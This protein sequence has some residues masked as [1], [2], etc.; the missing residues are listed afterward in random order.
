MYKSSALLLSIV[1]LAACS[2]NS[3]ELQGKLT[4]EEQNEI[5]DVQT[6]LPDFSAEYKLN[7]EVIM[8]ALDLGTPDLCE[9]IADQA[10]KSSC[11]S[12]VADSQAMQSAIDN[13]DLSACEKLAS[14][15][16]Q[17]RCE[18][19]VSDQLAKK[20]YDQEVEA[21]ANLLFEVIS[22]GSLEQCAEIEDSNFRSDCEV[23]LKM[24]I[25]AEQ[26][27]PSY[28]KGLDDMLKKSCLAASSR[29]E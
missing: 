17:T 27:D 25:A 8:R 4:L 3:S 15:N 11:L 24:Q 14:L 19:L 22:E 28:C 26:K 12:L 9:T 13:L 7:E 29:Q 10:Q 16:M 5:V 23:N 20:S 1:L 21:Q 6:T 2:S 18:I